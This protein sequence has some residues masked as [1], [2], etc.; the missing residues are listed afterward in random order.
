MADVAGYIAQLLRLNGR[1]AFA[2]TAAGGTILYLRRYEVVG[3]DTSEMWTSYGAA[4]GFWLLVA[5]GAAEIYERVARW[6]TA[7]PNYSIWKKRQWLPLRDAACLLGREKPG[8]GMSQNVS[9]LFA[10]L[11]ETIALNNIEFND[12]REGKTTGWPDGDARVHKNDLRKAVELMRK[13]VPN[14]LK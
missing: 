14:W 3:A 8:M 11:R 1:T 13:R 6:A 12:R 10:V 5:M 4:F 2:L 7:R 9:A